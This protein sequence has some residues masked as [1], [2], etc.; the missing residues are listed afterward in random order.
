[1]VT[2]IRW[3]YFLIV[4]NLDYKT[5]I[6]VDFPCLD[7]YFLRPN[8]SLKKKSYLDDRLLLVVLLSQLLGDDFDHNVGLEPVLRPGRR[9]HLLLFLPLLHLE[10][11]FPNANISQH[12]LCFSD[13]TSVSVHWDVCL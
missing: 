3:A 6:T 8:P 2:R 5:N 1:M 10:T 11:Q 9:R 12:F 13:I 7:I 4:V